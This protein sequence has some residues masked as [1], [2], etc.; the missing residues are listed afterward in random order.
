M[1]GLYW[2]VN[3]YLKANGKSDSQIRTLFE[4][5]TIMLQNDSDGRGDYLH[6]WGVD[7]LAQ[8]TQEQLDALDVTA[9]TSE[10]NRVVDITR[11]RDYGSWQS[12]LD[13][14]YHDIDSGKLG[15]DAKTGTWYLAVKKVKDDNPKS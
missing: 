8:P 4:K 12:Q 14:I 2:K 7:G 11:K 10:A 9:T 5:D 3:E 6:T 15:E 1:A 13:E